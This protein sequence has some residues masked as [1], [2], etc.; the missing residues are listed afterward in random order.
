VGY[1]SKSYSKAEKSYT[2]YNKEML[3]VMR[4]LEK[5]WSLLIGAAEPFKIWTDHQNLTYFQEP[6]KLTSRQVDWTTKL[7]DYN[8]MI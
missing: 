8:F 3:G 7:Q 6:Q 4:G 2:T 5:W 1:T